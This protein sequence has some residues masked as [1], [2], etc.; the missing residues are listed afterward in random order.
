[1]NQPVYSDIT[2]TTPESYLKARQN[3][4]NQQRRGPKI[5]RELAAEVW[6]E[7]VICVFENIIPP[8]DIQLVS[9]Y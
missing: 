3:Q 2:E 8:N 4:F 5:N 6:G 7:I 9:F 1:L